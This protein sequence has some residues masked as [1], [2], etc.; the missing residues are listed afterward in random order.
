VGTASNV[1]Q[2]SAQVPDNTYCVIPDGTTP[3]PNWLESGE[4]YVL[5][6]DL[7]G[8]ATFRIWPLGDFS[9]KVQ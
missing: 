9:I 7:I 1:V 5:Q 4:Y 3:V 2:V 6:D 8:R